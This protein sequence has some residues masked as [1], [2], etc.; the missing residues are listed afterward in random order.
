MFFPWIFRDFKEKY[1]FRTSAAGSVDE[2]ERNVEE[3]AWLLSFYFQI[4]MDLLEFS[5]LILD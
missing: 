5:L 4:A 3:T 2:I 1:F